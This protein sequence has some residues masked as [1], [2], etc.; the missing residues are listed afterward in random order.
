MT[1]LLSILAKRMELKW[2]RKNQ[3]TNNNTHRLK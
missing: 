3:K 1:R 2:L